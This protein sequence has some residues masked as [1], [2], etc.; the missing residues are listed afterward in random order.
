M[1]LD[2]LDSLGTEMKGNGYSFLLSNQEY[3][4]LSLIKRE[5]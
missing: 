4:Q 5:R 3:K 2:A 1:K